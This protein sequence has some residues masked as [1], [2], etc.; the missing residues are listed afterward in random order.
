ML[1]I[2]HF[3]LPL[4]LLVTLLKIQTSFVTYKALHHLT[5]AHLCPH[6]PLH[7]LHYS[8]VAYLAVSAIYQ[9]HFCLR[10]FAPALHPAKISL[11]QGLWMAGFSV[12]FRPQFKSHISRKAFPDRILSHCLIFFRTFITIWKYLV[13]LFIYLFV[14]LCPQFLPLPIH[15]ERSIKLMILFI[16]LL[17]LYSLPGL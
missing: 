10:A 9:L 14:L 4:L 1:I 12:A 11:H 2:S 5:P 7:S 15:K 17:L 13:Y 3:Y 8:Q 6:S 16:M